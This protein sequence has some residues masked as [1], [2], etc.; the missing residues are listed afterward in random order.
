MICKTLLLHENVVF[1]GL[2]ARS[3]L[4]HLPLLPENSAMTRAE[5]QKNMIMLSPP[6][7]DYLPSD[8]HYPLLDI[9]VP[10]SVLFDLPQEVL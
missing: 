9:L 6:Y 2:L 7:P 3:H 10:P 5:R 1:G 8:A 4:P